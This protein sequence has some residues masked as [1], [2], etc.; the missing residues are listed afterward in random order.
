M[1]LFIGKSRKDNLIYSER[2]YIRAYL[3]SEIGVLLEKE[4]K[5]DSGA[6]VIIM[7][8]LIAKMV[9]KVCTVVRIHQ[10]VYLEWMSICM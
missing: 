6:G 4:Y 1:I 8:M 9:T 5:G 7:C 3:G 10:N 2:K